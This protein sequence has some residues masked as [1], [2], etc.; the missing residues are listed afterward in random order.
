MSDAVKCLKKHKTD[1]DTG[2]NSNHLIHGTNLLN[3]YLAKLLT[4]L[5]SHGYVPEQ[6]RLS[7]I[8][9]IVKNNQASLKS[10]NNHRG[11]ALSS[12]I[13]KAMDIIILKSQQKELATSN[14]QFGF[15]E[16]T[17]TTHCT[18]V[19]E[20]VINY[21]VKNGSSVYV[22]LLDASK[23]LDR[24]QKDKLF[25][26]LS[27]RK[28]CAI[29]MRF[30]CSMY[31]NQMCR[32]KWSD[33]L[34]SKFNVENGVKQGGVLSPKLF[35]VYI[36]VLLERLRTKGT[37]C[38]VGNRFMGAF[39]YAD[40]I[41]LMSPSIT[42]L[43]SLLNVCEEF[44]ADYNINFN[45]SKSKLIVYGDSRKVDVFLQGNKISLSDSEKHVGNLLSN[46]ADLMSQKVHQA[47]NQLYA[48]VNVII[49][50]FGACDP[51]IMFKLFK[52]YC[53]SFYGCQL[54]NFGD[55]KNVNVAYIAWRKCVRRMLKLPYMTH[56]DLLYCIC[57][58]NPIN[59]QFH[60]RFTRFLMSILSSS[61]S[62]IKLAGKLALNGSQSAVCQ[63]INYIASFY[64]ISKYNICLDNVV[65]KAKESL[66]AKAGLIRDLILLR[67]TNSELS[68]LIDCSC[69]E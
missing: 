25:K 4:L 35:N 21:Y 27:E 43:K 8:I 28:M 56:S 46:R 30:L 64:N 7:T 44:S 29:I 24:V 33:S 32:V 26:I 20:E 36:D 53:T 66:A 51:F 18:F 11:I 6:M 37:G 22:T 47:C 61:N 45:A 13:S 55:L 23:A 9:P 41:I 14:L 59:V 5:L 16:K 60:R 65:H 57:E 42:A 63:S 68:E 52:S 17:S 19:V 31:I 12:I 39:S 67:E 54:W 49:R 3:V 69:T 38:Y 62:C 10:S 1:G 34:S 48:K 58:E 40:D 50:Q 2:H 15:T